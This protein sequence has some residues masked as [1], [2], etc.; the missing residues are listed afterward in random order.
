MA[1]FMEDTKTVSLRRFI[2]WTA[3]QAQYN[4]RELSKR[5]SGKN[6]MPGVVSRDSNP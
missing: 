1:A 6:K 2:W 5:E 3:G 4:N